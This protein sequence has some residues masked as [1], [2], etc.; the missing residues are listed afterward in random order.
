MRQEAVALRKAGYEVSVICPK[1]DVQDRSGFEIYEGIRV[2][3]YP[4][5]WQASSGPAYVLEYSWAMLCTFVLMIWIWLRHGLDYVHAANPPDL[6]AL[7]F[8]PFGLF[9][10]KFV[11]DQHDLCPETYESKFHRQDWVHRL[12]LRLEAHSYRTASLVLATNQSFRDIARTR[13]NVDTQKL[14]I[15]RSG[16]DLNHFHPTAPVP[17]LKRGFPYMVVYLGVMSLQD[18]VDRVI[19]AAY[20]LQRLRGRRDVLF[21]LI[22]KGDQWDNLREQARDLGLNGTVQ[23]TGR[24]P[25]PEMIEYLST[26]DVC[27]APDPPIHLNHMSTMNK[28]LEYMACSKPIVSFD[29]LESRRSAELAAVYVDRDD[30]KLLAEEID[31]LLNDPSRRKQIGEY[32]RA[33]MCSELDWGHSAKKLVDAYE[34]LNG[35][36]ASAAFSKM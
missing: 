4:L 11:Y 16:P 3:R 28:I 26:A 22:G 18:G 32:G 1:G 5:Y 15:V 23:F 6:F 20:H 31:A 24:I 19:S 21:S 14:V 27:I 12:L 35:T 25:D 33:R 9:G 10:K 34:R 29:L 2:Y 30:P 13:G 8:R 17:Q 36:A 7:L